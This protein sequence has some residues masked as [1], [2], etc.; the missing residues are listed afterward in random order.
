MKQII[1]NIIKHTCYVCA[2]LLLV[3]CGDFLEITP[4]DI[5]TE[6]NFWDEKKDV[7]QMVAGCYTA[8]QNHNF[9]ARCIVWGEVR[10]QD[11]D[12]RSDVDG[13]DDLYQALIN[14]LLPTNQFTDWSS[15]YHVINKCNTIIRMAPE[16]HEKDPA[17]R[18]SDVQATIAEMTALRSLCYW[19][20]I[21]AFDAVPFYREGI[22]QEDEIQS[23]PPMSFDNVLNELITDLESV[24]ADALEHYPASSVD[25][26]DNGKFNS[27]CNR[28][29]R[30]AINAML[31]DMY[32]WRGDYDKVIACADEIM[33]VKKRD[34]EKTY[35]KTMVSG[36]YAPEAISASS[37]NLTAYLYK[38]TSES[39]N[40]VFNAIFGIGNSYES[41]FE[42]SFNND[43]KYSP[44][45]KSSALGEYYGS[46]N[47]DKDYGVIN[48]GAGFLCP[49]S[50]LVNEARG[51][52]NW[53]VFR[54]ADDTRYFCSMQVDA[55]YNEGL[56][57][58]GVA[59]GFGV[60]VK[61]G[62]YINYTS[63][64]GEPFSLPGF[65]NRNWVFYRLTD[66]MLME[67]EAYVMKSTDDNTSDDNLA[68][69]SKAF[70]LVE[71]VSNR[72]VTNTAS[73][74]TKTHTTKNKNARHNRNLLQELLLNERR[75]ELVFEGKNWFDLLR[76]SRQAGYDVKVLNGVPSKCGSRPSSKPY[77]SWAHAF[78]PYNKDEVKKNPNLNQK[79]IYLQGDDEDES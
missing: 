73:Q 66:V 15:F 59:N 22:Q 36:S 24:K 79:G 20:L 6:D 32:L 29:T 60:A 34:Y 26:H 54:N 18:Q 70:D 46:G 45:I 75:A 43:E 19:Y 77:P 1:Q 67:A 4:R 55:S 42:I 64:D 33:S 38:N 27:N 2:G 31:C 11:V 71:V 16:V 25:D 12:G 57:R 56:I 53:S 23:L 61:D 72:S 47:G 78:W 8:M 41:L 58:K 76:Y 37:G 49:M 9:I 40:D 48:S 39:P 74:V 44:Y 63:S 68:L 69:W 51:E 17:Y 5:V 7:D 21:R 62:K 10:G 52:G 3:S 14:N 28:I 50:D 30:S 65:M 35:A 13:F